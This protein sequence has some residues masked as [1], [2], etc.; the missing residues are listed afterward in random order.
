M[1]RWTAS[2]QVLDLGL[3]SVLSEVRLDKEALGSE[4]GS[5]L[6]AQNQ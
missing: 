1:V 5:W 3:A 2:G 4:C 6:S